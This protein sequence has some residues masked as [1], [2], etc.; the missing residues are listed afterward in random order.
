MSY[1]CPICQKSI[2]TERGLIQHTESTH[3]RT[4]V[5]KGARAW[6]SWR[7]QDRALT[8]GVQAVDIT[9]TVTEEYA[10]LILLFSILVT[11][12]SYVF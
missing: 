2:S 3:G 7:G 10:I 4:G 11:V 6:E 8:T 12:I 5:Y 1:E 9:Y